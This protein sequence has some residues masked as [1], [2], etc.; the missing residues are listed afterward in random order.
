MNLPAAPIAVSST[1]SPFQRLYF[2][3]DKTRDGER[4]ADQNTEADKNICK[5]KTNPIIIYTL[6][7]L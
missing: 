5:I 2:K 1:T 7:R 6:K 3:P 4:H